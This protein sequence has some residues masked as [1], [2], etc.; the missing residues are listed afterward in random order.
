MPGEEAWAQ[1]VLREPVV[2]GRADRFVVRRP[3]PGETLGGGVI[4]DPV[5]RRLHRRRERATI[6]RLERKLQGEPADMLLDAA[7][8]AGPATVGALAEAAGVSVDEAIEGSRRLIGSG[9]LKDLR[10]GANGLTHES[11][12][13]SAEAWEALTRRAAGLLREYHAAHA[14]RFGMVREELKSRLGLAA[15]PFAACLEAWI[16]DGQLQDTQGTVGLAGHAPKPSSEDLTKIEQARARVEAARFSPP[17]AKELGVELGDEAFAYLVATR[18]IVPV[19]ADV[20]FSERA[21]AEIVERV[22]AL[23]AREGEATVSRI[24]QE[25]D[26]SRKYALA[27]LEHMDSLG[28]TVRDGDVRRLGPRATRS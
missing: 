7:Q 23:L 6:E 12:V 25:L 16:R 17:S 9:R 8:A 5:S 26:T 14:L 22:Q 28:L 24:R 4:V 10:P 2:A 18:A 19:S 3:S 20:V 15:K 1:L 13:V 27:L 11:L 21:Y